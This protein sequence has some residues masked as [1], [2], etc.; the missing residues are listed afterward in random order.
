MQL[1]SISFSLILC[2][3]L[4]N[5]GSAETC[6]PSTAST[7]DAAELDVPSIAKEVADEAP[8]HRHMWNP[9]LSAPEPNE[10]VW[11]AE[12]SPSPEIGRKQTQRDKKINI[13]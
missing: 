3:L 9:S 11:Y 10:S 8:L 2:N 6:W 12:A 4:T 5:I 13:C 1:V 7:A